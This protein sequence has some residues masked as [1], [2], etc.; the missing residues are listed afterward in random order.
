MLARQYVEQKIARRLVCDL[1]TAGYNVTVNDGVEDVL[2]GS[3]DP[4]AV[5][6]AMF[7]YYTATDENVLF[8]QGTGDGGG[9]VKLVYG[10]G[11]WDVISDYTVN[12]EP[13]LE[14]ISRWIDAGF[15]E[16]IGDVRTAVPP[17]RANP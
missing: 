10:N 16:M 15:A 4:F 9:W 2:S 6:H 5:L 13:V 14:P 12:L 7:G 8:V 17:P 1:L 3:R 11:G